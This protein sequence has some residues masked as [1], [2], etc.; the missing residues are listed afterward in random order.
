MKPDSV[1]SKTPKGT[2][3]IET[4]RH[5]LDHRL[6][7]LLIMVNGKASAAEIAKKFEQLGDVMPLLQELQ[8]QGFVSDGT[9][10]APPARA[11]P[12]GAAAA[13]SAGA[14]SFDLKQAKVDLCRQLRDQLGPDADMLT[15]KIEGCGSPEELRQFLAAKR[16][17][18]DEWLGKSKAAQFWAKA[19][20]Y[21]S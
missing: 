12:G 21:V 13:P 18:L 2:E 3:E 6:R 4:R 17:M 19:A 8:A 11:A 5:K 10:A 16:E 20:P 7:A 15:G 1:L 9:A 14:A